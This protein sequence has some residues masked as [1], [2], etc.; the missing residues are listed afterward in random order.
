[1]TGSMGKKIREL[2]SIDTRSLALFRMGI[3]LV[4]LWDLVDRSQDLVA[5]YTDFGV[6]P[7]DVAIS[8]LLAPWNISFHLISG[9]WQIQL[10][11][12]VV[13]AF[14][15]LTLLIGYKTRLSTILSWLLLSSLHN[16]N[17]RQR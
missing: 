12:F 11:L 7:R 13:A 3:A 1:M 2:F 5:H 8:S 6:L 14:F 9:N 4:L 17:R 16:R 10:L 15:A